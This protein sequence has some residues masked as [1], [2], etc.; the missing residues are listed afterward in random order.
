MMIRHLVFQGGGVKGIAYVGAIDVLEQRGLMSHVNY[1]AGTSAGSIT[2][3]LLAMGATSQDLD[4]VLRNTSFSSFMDGGGW[5]IGDAVRLL[6]HYGIYKGDAF[7]KWLRQQISMLTERATG[8]AQPDMTFGQLRTLAAQKPGVFRE[9]YTVSTNLSRQMPEV[10]SAE[11]TPDVPVS[12]A[13]R[14]SMSIRS[15]SKR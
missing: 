8:Q 9:L 4:H 7:E 14:M 11:S 12:L 3:A 1:V 2:A 6:S 13:V 10:F 5:V 15:S